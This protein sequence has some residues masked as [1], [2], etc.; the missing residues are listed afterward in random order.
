MK[1]EN[2]KDPLLENIITALDDSCEHLDDAS[3]SRLRQVRENA[4]LKAAKPTLWKT[5]KMPLAALTTTAAALI[6]A[7]LY[8]GTPSDIPH[9]HSSFNDFE[10]LMSEESPEFYEDLDF[11]SWL[12]EEQDSAYRRSAQPDAKIHNHYYAK[13]QRVNAEVLKYRQK[14]RCEYQ[15]CRCHVHKHLD[16]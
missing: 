2:T 6:V 5:F 12:A 7:F 3:L 16:V 11:Y 1:E 9:L 14:N 13:V 4:L 15:D 10:M 8:I